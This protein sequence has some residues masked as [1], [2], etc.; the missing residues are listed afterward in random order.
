VID[1]FFYRCPNDL[2]CGGG[3]DHYYPRNPTIDVVNGRMYIGL[4]ANSSN[5]GTVEAG[6]IEIS[7]FP[8]LFDT[9]LTFIPAQ[10]ALN[11][12][13]PAHPDGFRSADSLQVWT[14]DI[15]SMP[16]WSQAQVLACNAATNPTPGHVL[17]VADTLPD[18]AVGQGR[19]Y[20][21]ASENGGLRRLGRRYLNGAYSAREPSG[22]PVCE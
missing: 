4:Y 5:G 14:G 3:Y 9:L 12:V 6:I 19:Y 13:T 18:P 22:L 15:R 10:Q 7:G 17:S 8:E 2:D 11:I 21:V 20:L 1:V 16:D